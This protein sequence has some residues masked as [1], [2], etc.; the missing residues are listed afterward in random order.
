MEPEPPEAGTGVPGASTETAHFDN[1]DG[2][3]TVFPDEP[4]DVSA[5]VAAKSA[6]FTAKIAG[7]PVTRRLRI[8]PGTAVVAD[9]EEVNLSRCAPWEA[10]EVTSALSERFARVEGPTVASLKYLC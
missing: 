8:V 4:H 2:E 6:A 9:P 5:I 10:E 7:R 1:V 3:V